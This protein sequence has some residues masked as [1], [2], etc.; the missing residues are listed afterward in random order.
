MN[1]DFQRVKALFL[2]AAEKPTP[3]DRCAFLDEACGDDTALRAQVKVLLGAHDDADG[4]LTPPA[5]PKAMDDD[6]APVSELIGTFIG[7][8]KLIEQIGEGGMGLVF[9]AEQKSPSAA[10]SPSSSS[11]PAWTPSRSSDASS[12]SAKPSL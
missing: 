6:V 9:M 12:P 2:D 10:R 5:I 1:P 11:S 7:P 4:F 3:A 8:Y